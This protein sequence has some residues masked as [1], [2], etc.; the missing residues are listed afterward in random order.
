MFILLLVAG[1][2][3]VG[4]VPFAFLLA[5]HVGGVDIRR[6]GSG[7]VGAANVARTT[8]AAVALGVVVLDAAKGAAA[9][10]LAGRMAGGSFAPAVTGL[11]AILG[12]VYPVWLG[13]RG[14]KGV[15]TSCG[16]FAMLAPPATIIAGMVFVM[17]VWY[18]RYVSVGS[19]LA[20]VA[21]GPLTYVTDAPPATVLA[22]VA[23]AAVIVQRH[24]S[25]LARL[26]A[27]T[28][29]RLGQRA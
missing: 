26:Q 19:V 4:S 18:S 20:S 9:V 6:A 17:A 10:V 25:N 29:R 14:G 22:A 3:F 23:T 16:V 27:G 7:N 11:A 8:G 5:R 15:A 21:L 28:E 13:F 2:Y 12:H 1:G 24:R